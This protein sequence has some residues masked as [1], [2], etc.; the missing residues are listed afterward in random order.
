[1]RA[2]TGHSPAS[3]KQFFAVAA[4]VLT[5]MVVALGIKTYMDG[6]A[7]VTV[8]AVPLE[9]LS[10]GE[11]AGLVLA[12]THW[13]ESSGVSGTRTQMVVVYRDDRP[14]ASGK[15]RRLLCWIEA[16]NADMAC[17]VIRPA[18]GVKP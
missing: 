7:E 15:G 8:P 12:G 11:L 16:P 4:A 18:T 2:M 1:M 5:C 9:S 17:R 13:T 14:G 6:A 3:G 10:E